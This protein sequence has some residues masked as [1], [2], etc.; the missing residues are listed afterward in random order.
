MVRCPE[1]SC[2]TI[3]GQQRCLACGGAV[4]LVPA[5]VDGRV[6]PPSSGQGHPSVWLRFSVAELALL[7][8]LAALVVSLSIGV[9]R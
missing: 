3:D 6:L 9:L 1:C 7:V 8:V 4:G 5:R 2:P